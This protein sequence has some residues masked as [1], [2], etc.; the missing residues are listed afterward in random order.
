LSREGK[1]E[2]GHRTALESDDMTSKQKYSAEVLILLY[3]TG[4]CASALAR[5]Q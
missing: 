3:G 2:N 4:L 1:D 5:A